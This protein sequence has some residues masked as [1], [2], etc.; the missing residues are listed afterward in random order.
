MKINMCKYFQIDWNTHFQ[1]IKFMYLIEKVQYV[2]VIEYFLYTIIC[3]W[4]TN[5]II[6]FLF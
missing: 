3:E 5:T 4:E 1:K 2:S 6:L